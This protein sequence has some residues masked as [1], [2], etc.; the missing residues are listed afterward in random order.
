MKKII[1]GLAICAGMY[2]CQK[3]DLNQEFPIDPSSTAVV[4]P[5]IRLVS[6]NIHG[7]KGP[8]G[9]GTLDQNL[10][11]FTELL[12]G[13]H[14]VC[15]Q[16]VVP[17]E[18]DKIKS[19]FPTYQY[20]YFLPQVTTKNKWK[21]KGGGNAIFSKLPILYYDSKLIQT[22]PGGD[23]WQRKAQFVKVQ[24]GGQYEV[25]NLFHYHNTYNWHHDDSQ[26]EKEGLEKFMSYISES[27]QPDDLVVATGDFNLISFDALQIIS[28]PP[29]TSYV[30]N[31]VD[32]VFSSSPLLEQN[33]YPTVE[34]ELSDHNAVWAIVCN[35]EC[36]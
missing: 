29:F 20:R 4:V 13:E 12:E 11:A 8:A 32:Y 31:W 3:I 17:A 1:T 16:E 35:E 18:W 15:L 7:G 6:Y 10:T 5:N 28:E 33:F 24:V 21:K 2:S 23:R 19:L 27:I 34:L 30:S 36:N 14:I 25:L 9:E 26:S 22:D